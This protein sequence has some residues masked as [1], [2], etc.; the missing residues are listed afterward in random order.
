VKVVLWCQGLM[1]DAPRARFA[2]DDRASVTREAAA[3]RAFNMVNGSIHHLEATDLELRQR[4]SALN[5][6]VGLG[7]GDFVEVNGVKLRCNERGFSPATEDPGTLDDQRRQLL[8]E[9]SAIPQA[10]LS[11][12]DYS[13]HWPRS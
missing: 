12:T 10:R 8:I 11:A 1:D 6:G 9:S 5:P 4:F 3:E 2:Y 13:I 7:V